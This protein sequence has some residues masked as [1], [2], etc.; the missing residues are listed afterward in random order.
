MAKKSFAG[1]G[2]DLFL[3][4]AA[5]FAPMEETPKELK[6]NPAF[7]A[8]IP[9]LT[10][11]EKAQLEENL[12]E[13]GIREP[14]STWNG[15]IIDGHNRYGLAKKH[16]LEFS[17]VSYEFQ[18]EADVI[19]WIIKNQFGRR[20]L[21]AWNRSILALKLK[22][23]IAEKAKINQKLSGGTVHQISDEPINTNFE[24]AKIANVSHDTIGKVQKIINEGTPDIINRLERGEVSVNKAHQELRRT[25]TVSGPPD[26]P[27]TE[28]AFPL[29]GTFS[30]IYADPP[31]ESFMLDAIKK[32][33]IP[34]AENAVLFLWSTPAALDKAMQIMNHWGFRYRSSIIW[35]KRQTEA[36]RY[37]RSRHEI[38]LIGERGKPAPP[39]EGLRVNSVY[40]EKRGK[41]DTKPAWFYEQIEQMFPNERYLE[42]FAQKRFSE[43]WEL[44]V[45]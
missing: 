14:I 40:S 5:D 21:S 10:D 19:L 15:T 24:L 20:N 12:L 29:K 35:D 6:I 37:V 18:N 34:A 3:T 33:E 2:A 16:G 13:N 8:L 36:D 27:K 41:N 9:E 28:P 17:A 44:Y 4:P 45:I 43:K 22:P 7:Q 11:E 31:W 25:K 23:V 1:T 30:L 38:L 32:L 26:I 39:A 42:L